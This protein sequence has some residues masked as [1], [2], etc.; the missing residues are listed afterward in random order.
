M[1]ATNLELLGK[2]S[3]SYSLHQRWIDKWNS[4]DLRR[5][6][7]V[8]EC[9]VH[10]AYAK[11]IGINEATLP[12]IS[13]SCRDATRA[14][15]D[16]EVDTEEV[17]SSEFESDSDELTNVVLHGHT[18][19]YFGDNDDDDEDFVDVGRL[20]SPAADRVPALDSEKGGLQRFVTQAIEALAGWTIGS[21]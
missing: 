11:S 19:G 8:A 2:H 5:E 10:Q 9:S 3:L 13:A 12:C 4:Q 6:N 16:P 20:W 7:N 21:S 18:M 17:Y 1:L 14:P 15:S